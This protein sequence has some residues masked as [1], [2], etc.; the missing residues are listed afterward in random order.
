MR[1]AISAGKTLVVA[2]SALSKALLLSLP[3]TSPLPAFPE[4]WMRTLRVLQVTVASRLWGVRAVAPHLAHPMTRS[5]GCLC[6]ASWQ[7]QKKLCMHAL[8]SGTVGQI[9]V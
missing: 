6:A 2:L 9:S 4:L 8:H 1:P 5:E 7:L 3:L